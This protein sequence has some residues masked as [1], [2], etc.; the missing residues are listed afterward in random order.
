MSDDIDQNMR[1]AKKRRVRKDILKKEADSAL[2]IIED[3]IFDNN[4]ME[5][6]VN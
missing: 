2:Q 1:C 5:V 4:D 6:S 3:V